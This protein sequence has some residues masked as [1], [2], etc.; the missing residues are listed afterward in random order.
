MDYRSFLN[1]RNNRPSNDQS[2]EDIK[3]T[4]EKYA[5]KSESEL[6][7]DIM[8]AV[9]KEKAEGTY[10]EQKLNDFAER[11]S[12]MLTPEQKNRLMQAIKMIKGG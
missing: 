9:Q 2:K 8:Q 11:V 12:P 10:S 3:K 1:K 6:L 4:A 5:G 7:G